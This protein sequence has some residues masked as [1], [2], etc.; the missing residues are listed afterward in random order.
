MSPKSSSN[1]SKEGYS[2]RN[3]GC[4]TLQAELVSLRSQQKEAITEI[5]MLKVTN[6][7]L[8]T[9]LEQIQ[10]GLQEAREQPV[11]QQ[12]ESFRREETEG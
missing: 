7:E 12:E 5:E 1:H 4:T 2:H 10:Q 3:N 8:E 11:D 6:Q 9:K